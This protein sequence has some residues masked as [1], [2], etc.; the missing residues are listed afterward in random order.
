MDTIKVVTA[1]IIVSE[2]KI[3]LTRRGKNESVPGKWEFPGGKVEPGET[4]KQCLEREL[5][6][7]LHIAT[8]SGETLG[9]SVYK[10]DHGEFRLIAISSRIIS[11]DIKLSVHDKYEWVELHDLL[12]FDLAPADL[13]LAKLIMEKHHV[14]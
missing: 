9:E 7:E 1:G 14:L 8:Q 12:S 2:G 11:G 4:V 3:L 6:E 5:F 13:P 10:Y